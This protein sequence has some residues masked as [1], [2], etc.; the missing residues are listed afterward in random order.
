MSDDTISIGDLVRVRLPNGQREIGTV[1]SIRSMGNYWSLT[2]LE[3][4]V[5]L[6]STPVLNYYPEYDV[7]K[8]PFEGYRPN[9]KCT[10]GAEAVYRP[11]PPPGHAGHCDLEHNKRFLQ[12]ALKCN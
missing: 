10:C 12:G 6:E 11:K 4:G 2:L 5:K 7:S 8:V 1:T 3:Y 9:A